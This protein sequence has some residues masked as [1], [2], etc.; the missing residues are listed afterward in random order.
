[1][2]K[3]KAGD[4]VVRI[5]STLGE[6]NYSLEEVPIGYVGVVYEG[7]TDDDYFDFGDKFKYTYDDEDFVL[8]ISSSPLLSKSA[9]G[10]FLESAQAI[11]KV[12]GKACIDEITATISKLTAIHTYVD[13]VIAELEKIK[14]EVSK[15]EKFT[16]EQL[17]ILSASVKI[18]K[19][20]GEYYRDGKSEPLFLNGSGKI[21]PPMNTQL[22]TD[23]FSI[24]EVEGTL[25]GISL[26]K[27][28][29]LTLLRSF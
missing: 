11:A 4:V 22:P 28:A 21:R 5:N 8:A 14:D 29:I 13:D 20:V 3:F 19:L 18:T 15:V 9:Y 26:D 6:S 24:D 16:S 2:S 25:A 17:E 27:E 10:E 7:F 12:Q 1:M 23:T